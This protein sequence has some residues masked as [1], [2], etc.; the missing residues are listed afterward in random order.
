MATGPLSGRRT[1]SRRLWPA[2]GVRRPSMGIAA[3]LYRAPVL[4]AVFGG[5]IGTVLVL[6]WLAAANLPD[7]WFGPELSRWIYITY[8][9][10]SSLF[11]VG[12]GVLAFSLQRSFEAR[13]SEVNRELGGLLLDGGTGLSPEEVIDSPDRREAPDEP[14]SRDLEAILETLGEA[15][16]HDVLMV[17]PKATGED[18]LAVHRLQLALLHRRDD[19]ERRQRMLTSFLPGPAG[20]AV[21]ILGVSA[22]MLPASEGMLQTLYAMNTAVILGFAYAW[23]GLAAYFALSVFGVVWSLRKEWKPLQA[24]RLPDSL[25]ETP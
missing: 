12:L 20:V 24:L 5:Y 11:L 13:R 16:D 21:G 3:R 10:A 19:L 23:I 14:R 15:Q 22:A 1:G 17:P 8:V 7:P 25:Q 2:S 6:A 18:A 9:L 4:A